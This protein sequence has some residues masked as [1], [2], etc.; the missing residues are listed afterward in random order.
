MSVSDNWSCISQKCP[1]LGF[2]RVSLYQHTFLN[3]FRSIEIGETPLEM[4]LSFVKIDA[5][6]A[7][8]IYTNMKPYEYLNLQT[9]IGA[10]SAPQKL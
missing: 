5:S 4:S 10:P 6:A 7:I 8:C 9:I 2:L 1:S 3:T